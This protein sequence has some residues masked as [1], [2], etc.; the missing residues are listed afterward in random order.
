MSDTF[1]NGPEFFPEKEIA[2]PDL[3]CAAFDLKILQRGRRW[4]WQVFDQN[5]TSVLYGWQ[6]SRPIA[7]YYGYRA[8]FLL[9]SASCVSGSAS[10]R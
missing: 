8:L 5:G 4:K 1:D 9:L 2:A 7:R 10:R 3:P 6:K